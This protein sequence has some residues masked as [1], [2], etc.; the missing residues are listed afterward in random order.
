MD[1]ISGQGGAQLSVQAVPV[2]NCRSAST[3]GRHGERVSRQ[4]NTAATLWL[5]CSR[6][7]T[8]AARAISPMLAALLKYREANGTLS[9]MRRSS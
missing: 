9:Q 4:V 2:D 8:P 5:P 3:G 1:G 7:N 6:S